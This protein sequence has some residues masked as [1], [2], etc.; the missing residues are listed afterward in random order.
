MPEKEFE[1]LK[2][3][4]RILGTKA[5]MDEVGRIETWPTLPD[6]QFKFGSAMQGNLMTQRGE[7]AEVKT[8]VNEGDEKALLKCIAD[9]DNRSH[10]VIASLHSHEG[11]N[12]NWY[13]IY[14]PEFVEQYAHDA[15]DA[16]ADV[17]VCHGAHFSRG[18]EIYK[19]HPIFYNLGSLIMEFEAGNSMISP[20]MYKT[21]YLDPNEA[22]P[23]DLHRGRAKD[24]DG[25]WQG[26]YSERR[27]SK[28]FYVRADVEEKGT[29]N[30]TIVPL[31][32]DM[33]REDCLKRGLP[34]IADSQVGREIAN[35]PTQMSE[36]YGTQFSYCEADGTI[37]II[38]N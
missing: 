24:K 34:Q 25:N 19:G 16:G 32:L 27:F 33:R 18:V 10:F 11:L 20:E 17:F 35:D 2:E 38:M 4:D 5:S 8:Y 37:Q 6:G 31:D 26:F 30:Y 22:Q 13:G 29:V 28:N 3:I 15:I 21:Y 9:A 7:K 36:K 12:E 23:S 14:P 1:Q